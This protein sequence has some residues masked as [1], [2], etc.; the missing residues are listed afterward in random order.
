MS[1]EGSEEN[2]GLDIQTY[3]NPF[4]SPSLKLTFLVGSKCRV[5]G[6]VGGPFTRILFA[7]LL[8]GLNCIA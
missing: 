1:R 5:K 4:H 7:I 3:A 8:S 6:G 2:L